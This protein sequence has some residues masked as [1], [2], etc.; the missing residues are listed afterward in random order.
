VK[1]RNIFILAFVF[2][3]S[4]C[5]STSTK[6]EDI[7][8][9]HSACYSYI[10]GENGFELNYQKA[11]EW[12]STAA[13]LGGASAQTLLAELYLEGNGVEKNL[14]KAA[15]LYEKAA[16]QNHVHAQLM[17]FLVQNVY[18]REQSTQEEKA[19]GLIFLNKSREAGYPKAIVIYNKIYG[20]KI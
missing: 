7:D 18:R 1:Y 16:L 15:E 20:Q 5:S 3:V 17:M 12:C 8:V 4:A 9:A 10:Y 13:S 2:I 19:K 14:V 6:T 11:F